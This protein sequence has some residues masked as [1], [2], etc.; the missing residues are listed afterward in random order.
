MTCSSFLRL[1]IY[2]RSNQ[3]K[4]DIKFKYLN[5]YYQKQLDETNDEDDVYKLECLYE[6][7]EQEK[8]L[9]NNDLMSEYDDSELS[10]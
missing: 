9:C 7:W 3:L 2:N 4:S 5:Y 6:W 8:Y 1:I 10:D